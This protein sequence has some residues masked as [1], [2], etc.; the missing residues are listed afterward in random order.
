[1]SGVQDCIVGSGAAAGILALRLAEAGRSVI[2]LEEGP[3]ELPAGYAGGEAETHARLFRS[4]A[5]LCSWDGGMTLLQ[6]RC[7]GGS[8]TVGHGVCEPL[9]PALLE[10]WRS[11]HGWTLD[12]GEVREA[13]RRVLARLET[14]P[15]PDEGHNVNNR[16]LAR[17]ARS[18]GLSVRSPA[19]AARR[20]DPTGLLGGSVRATLEKA[21]LAGAEI[22]TGAW[23]T[24]LER[25]GG[26]VVAATGTDLGVEAERFILC[27]GPI[28][29]IDLLRRSRVKHDRLGHDLTLD[30]RMLVVARFPEEV[31]CDFGASTSICVER[32]L[33]PVAGSGFMIEGTSIT[34]SLAAGQ[35]RLPLSEL[36]RLLA[37]WKRLAACWC[38]VTERGGRITW[39]TKG[40]RRIERSSRSATEKDARAALKAAARAMLAA[41]ARE[42]ALPVHGLPT[43]RSDR[44]LTL[45]DEAELRHADLPALSFAV[46]GGCCMDDRGPVDAE[47]RLRPA[48]NVHV[49]DASLFP[50]GAGPRPSVPVMTMGEMLADRLI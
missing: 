11:D 18:T 20:A 42:V 36:R 41:G 9:S 29:G 43:L 2:V 3:G 38:V 17:G 44:D 22:R 31:R 40:R 46:Q 7:L 4:G 16:L 30:R 49:C 37:D 33:D 1:M 26:R 6:G 45:I 5:Q 8:T 25:D 50:G 32:D 39:D 15:L 28:H 24:Y 19:I 48:P 13:G 35:L 27:T 47:F 14:A 23:V 34:P 10:G 21:R 12:A